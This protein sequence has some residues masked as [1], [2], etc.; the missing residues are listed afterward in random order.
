MIVCKKCNKAMKSETATEFCKCCYPEPEKVPIE[1]TL[2]GK[3]TPLQ[4]EYM[5]EQIGVLKAIN[6]IYESAWTTPQTTEHDNSN[7]G[8]EHK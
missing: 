2:I 8:Q 7:D 4:K 5:E 6:K 1:N 3:L